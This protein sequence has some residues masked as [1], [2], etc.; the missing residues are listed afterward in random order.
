MKPLPVA[1]STALLLT[2]M[3]ASTAVDRLKIAKN[4][5]SNTE[6]KSMDDNKDGQVSKPEFLKFQEQHFDKIK[7][8]NG[9][10]SLEKIE[11]TSNHNSM[12]EKAIGTT[13]DSPNVNDRDA[14]NGSKY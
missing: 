11:Q 6:Y 3:D 14:V 1:L 7:Q 13:S 4:C 8:K 10:V 9:M 12:N 5:D 2:S